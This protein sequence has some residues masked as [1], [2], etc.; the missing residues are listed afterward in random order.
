VLQK[1]N[2]SGFCCVNLG[3]VLEVKAKA[4][5]YS[6]KQTERRCGGVAAETGRMKQSFL[7]RHA[8]RVPSSEAWFFYTLS[9]AAA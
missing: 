8:P 5:R 6:L 4:R 2:F 3:K 9:A 1:T 7:L